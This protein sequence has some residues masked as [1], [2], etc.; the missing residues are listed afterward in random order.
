MWVKTQRPFVG[1]SLLCLVHFRGDLGAGVLLLGMLDFGTV[2][3]LD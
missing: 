3:V 2:D 1:K